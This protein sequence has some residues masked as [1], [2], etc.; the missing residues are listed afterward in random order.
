LSNKARIIILVFFIIFVILTLT[1]IFGS[2]I[3]E[4][5]TK[6][7]EYEQ[8]LKE[9]SRE[10]TLEEQVN[11]IQQL[12][13]ICDDVRSNPNSYMPEMVDKCR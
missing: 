10:L 4:L 3:P 1:V 5:I 2:N 6:D 7:L 9:K 12:K 11:A 13:E 8:S